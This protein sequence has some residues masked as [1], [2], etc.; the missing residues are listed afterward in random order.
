MSNFA[1][2]HSVGDY[3]LLQMDQ[4]SGD[5]ISNLKLQKLCY[6]AQAWH[7]T[8]YSQPLFQEKIKAW[9][10]GPV[11]PDLYHRFKHLRWSCIDPSDIRTDPYE[12]FHSE[13]LAF[14]QSVW[15]RYSPLSGRELE[16]LTH[17]EDPWRLAYGDR[18]AGDK[19]DVEITL[20][21]MRAFYGK[22]LQPAQ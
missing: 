9:A 17:S 19:C 16:D 1:S 20:D 7:Y 8:L 14:L 13:T 6:Y 21:S 3:F 4:N 15:E 22:Q 11:I 5:T 10:H 2:A 12:D 18:P